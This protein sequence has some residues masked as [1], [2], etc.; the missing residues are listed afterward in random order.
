MTKVLV[1][2]GAINARPYKIIVREILGEDVE[3]ICTYNIPACANHIKGG[4]INGVIIPEGHGDWNTVANLESHLGGEIPVPVLKDYA[5]TSMRAFDQ[6]YTEEI[7]KKYGESR[8]EI[9][10]GWLREE[11]GKSE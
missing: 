3:V 10:R 8:G 1:T 11:V 5:L 9:I 7:K 6:K 4:Q 2:D